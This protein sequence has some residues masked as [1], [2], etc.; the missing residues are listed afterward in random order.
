MQLTPQLQQQ[1]SQAVRTSMRIEGY[2]A[3]SLPP[4]QAKAK[5]L[6]ELGGE[7]HGVPRQAF[8]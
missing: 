3:Q 8:A 5:A 2:R 6:M 1:L 4:T 7:L